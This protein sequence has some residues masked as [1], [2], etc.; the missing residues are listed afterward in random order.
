MESSC[1][2]YFEVYS[3]TKMTYLIFFYSLCIQWYECS[4]I[5]F[6]KPLLMGIYVASKSFFFKREEKG[7]RKTQRETLM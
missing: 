3:L 4:L 2:F 5:N 7:G 6:T 1:T